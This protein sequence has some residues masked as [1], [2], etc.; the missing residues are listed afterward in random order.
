MLVLLFQYQ[1]CAA[2]RVGFALLVSP[3]VGFIFSYPFCPDHD[4]HPS[5]IETLNSRNVLGGILRTE[6]YLFHI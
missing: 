1:I 4:S 2:R 5:H 6:L 3:F